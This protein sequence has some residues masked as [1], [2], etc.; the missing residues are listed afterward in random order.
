MFRPIVSIP[1]S[2][3][4]NDIKNSENTP[5]TNKTIIIKYTAFT[6]IGVKDELFTD[7][8]FVRYFW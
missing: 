8:R 4:N 3:P 1:I 5:E 2:T 7:F 6:I